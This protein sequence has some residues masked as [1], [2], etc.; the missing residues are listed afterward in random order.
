MQLSGKQCVEQE[1]VRGPHLDRARPASIDLT[2]GRIVVSGE[3]QHDPVIQPQQTFLIESA[4]TVKVPNGYVGYAMPK[5]SL[6]N[7]G[8]LVLNTGLVDPGYNGT[9][10]TIAIN[11]SNSAQ[12]IRP[13]TAFLRLVFHKLEGADAERADRVTAPTLEVLKARSRHFGGSFLDVPGQAD[14]ITRAVTNEVMDRQR[15]AILLLISTIGFLFV[16]WNL[17]SFFLLARQTNAIAD[18]TDRRGS[19]ELA[20]LEKQMD[21]L[22]ER[23]TNLQTL[24]TPPKG[25]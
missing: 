3:E 14:R 18:R 24:V 16:M 8:V 17:G 9:L 2:V 15:N 5:T 13:D 7:D 20:R 25:R 4:Q 11:F 12:R 21:K 6:C 22:D 10:S 23:V 19:A 1:F